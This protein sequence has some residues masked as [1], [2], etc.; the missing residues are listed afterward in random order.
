[1]TTPQQGARARRSGRQSTR[2]RRARDRRVLWIGLAASL[3]LHVGIIAGVSWLLTRKPRSPRTPSVPV[4]V[5]PAPGIRAVE[6]VEVEGEPVREPDRPEEPD[7]PDRDAAPVVAIPEP[8]RERVADDRTAADRLAPRVVDPRLW[9]PV[10]LIPREPTLDE[11]EAR[12][13]AAV[14]LLSDSALAEAEAAVRARDW[15]VEDASGGRWGISPGQLHLGKLT[16]PLPIWFSVDAAMGTTADNTWYELERQLDRTRILD[17][18]EDRVRAIRER[19]DR[20]RAE[21]RA[22]DNGGG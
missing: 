4:L 5:A 13:S 18:F 1:M 17:S 10:I 15:T 2:D 11:V 21:R 14:E 8:E 3:L 7:E 9:R 22:A 19:R 16:L 12:I 6:I 20:E